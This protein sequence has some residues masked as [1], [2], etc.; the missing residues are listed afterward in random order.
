[1]SK[2]YTLFPINNKYLNVWNLYKNHPVSFL[3]S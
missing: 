2:N 1:M 3:D